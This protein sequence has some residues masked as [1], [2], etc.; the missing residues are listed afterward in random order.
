MRFDLTTLVTAVDLKARSLAASSTDP[1]DLV[2][3]GKAIEAMT[4][5]S[6][7]SAV[8]AQG[9]TSVAAVA[10]Q[11][12]TSVAAVATA[13]TT[14]TNALN[15]L[16]FPTPTSTAVNKTLANSEFVLVTASGKTMTLPAG[17]AGA[18]QVFV[19]V[20]IF[21][22]TVLAPNHSPTTVTKTVTVVNSG[23]NK[24]ALDGTT[25]PAITLH[26]GSTYIFDVSHS[27]NAGHPL[28]FKNADDSAY[29]TGVTVTGTAGSS[30]AKVTIVVAA[31]A[32]STL[33]YSCSVHGTGMGNAITVE[34]QQKIMGLAEN[35]TLDRKNTVITLQFHSDAAGWRA[36]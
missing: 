5:S 28:V 16:A 27:S 10:A 25:N 13:Q 23:G 6:S 33:K 7:V 35:L 31:D 29:T 11:E 20:E 30:G 14:A 36:Y 21:V 9:T 2:F 17:V 15:A 12:T 19:S 24:F 18:S 1:K 3:I 8:V 26:R 32:P 22:D 34:D 4:P